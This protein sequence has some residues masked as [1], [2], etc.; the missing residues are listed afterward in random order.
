MMDPGLG[1]NQGVKVASGGAQTAIASGTYH[2]L[3]GGTGAGASVQVGYGIASIKVNNPGSGYSVR[4]LPLINTTATN[5]QNAVIIPT[6]TSV[7][8]PLV[9]NPG[10][11]IYLDASGAMWL[12]EVSG[13]TVIG[14][15]STNLFSIDSSGNVIAKGSV[16]QNGSP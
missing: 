11:K 15:G 2:S 13:K 10:Q 4:P 1:N 7:A 9:L 3:N 8:A 6:M 12:Q 14:S 16:T 5:W